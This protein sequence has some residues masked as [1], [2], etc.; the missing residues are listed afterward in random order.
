MTISTLSRFFLKAVL[1]AGLLALAGCG[2]D[3]QNKNNNFNNDPYGNNIPAPTVAPTLNID[4]DTAVVTW[5]VVAG[6]SYNLYVGSS[7]SSGNKLNT[8]PLTASPAT[9]TGLSNFSYGSGNNS[10][11]LT[12]VE[13][14]V[15]SGKG[16]TTYVPLLQEPT[17]SN[18]YQEP[19][20]SFDG[21]QFVFSGIYS[22]YS[23]NISLYTL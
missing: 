22:N 3:N 7:G 14:N 2:D 17:F 6:E 18:S 23:A 4:G 10:F 9:I 1:L 15:E 12:K 8:T 16:P 13:N 11:W 20:S 5:T 19:R 21:T